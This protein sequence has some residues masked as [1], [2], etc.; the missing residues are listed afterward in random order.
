MWLKRLRLGIALFVV[1]FA[2]VVG[3][4]LRKGHKRIAQAPP[5]VRQD[6]TASI[7]NPQGGTFQRTE[8]GKTTFSL[9]FGSQLTYA[10]GR[11]KL[12]KGV[13]VTFLDKDGRTVNISSIEANLLNPPDRGLTHA[14]FSGGVTLTTSDG[15]S[16]K[17]AEATYDKAQEMVRVPGAVTFS[18]GRMTGS[19]SAATYDFSHEVLSVMD[20]AKMDVT[21]D[22]KGAGVVHV[23]SK[24]ALMARQEHY[25]K[26]S[27]NAHLEGE[28]RV[29]DADQATLF[30]SAD[31]KLIQRME[32]RGHSRITASAQGTGGPQSMDGDNIDLVYGEDGRTLKS[33]K[34]MEN[35]SVQLPGQAGATGRRVAGRTIDITMGNDGSTVT[36]LNAVEN[37]QVDLPAD[38]DTPARRIRSAAL[39]ASGAEGAGLQNAV[40]TG[41]VDFRET[42]AAKKDV[43]AI[44][45]T[46]KSMRLEV[47]TKPGFGDVERA[48]FHGNVH[49]TDGAETSADSSLAIYNVAQDRLELSPSSTG[50]PG[51]GPHVA[52]GRITVDAVHIQMALGSQTLT[53]DTKVKSVVVQ[54]QNRPA[55]P[56][57]ASP[58]RPGGRGGRGTPAPVAPLPAPDAQPVHMPAMLKQN[59]PVNVT[60]NRLDYDGSNSRA[61]YK[62]NARLWQTDTVIQADTIVLDDKSGNLH[63]ITNVRTVM[64]L[65]QAT[66]PNQTGRGQTAKDKPL[67]DSASKDPAKKP[68]VQPTTTVAEELVYEDANRKATYTTKAHMNGPDGDLTADRIELFLTEGGGELERAEADGS[69]I[70]REQDRRAYGDHLTYIAAKDE[71][72]MVGKPVKVFD[73][74]PPDCKVTHGTTLTFH[75][76]VDTISATGNGVSAGTRTETIACGTAGQR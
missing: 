76:A 18:K 72:T 9:K 13:D 62:G 48:D 2:I 40:F 29:T 30:L 26:F 46:A 34:L 66:D 5:P 21:P 20:Q 60:A 56:A 42:R 22:E 38:G 28:G 16:L 14:E 8:H 7:E 35:A 68:P 70:S 44:D 36:G 25:V 53:A 17:G 55:T 43:P 57:Q 3:V 45:R 54:A 73:D 12:G 61:T 51:R 39:N 63:A 74:K 4:S 67:K 33:A 50:D 64:T 58:A 59:E 19:G 32:L 65:S 15:L 1:I 41:N 11:S 69:V 31:D 10:D 75:K 6:P 47:Q 37:V 24:A 52:N 49:F 71:Y 27:L 23:T